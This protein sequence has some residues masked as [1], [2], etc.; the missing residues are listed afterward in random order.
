MTVTIKFHMDLVVKVRLVFDESWYDIATNPV[1]QAPDL[2]KL[3]PTAWSQVTDSENE[4]LNF[5]VNSSWG[6]TKDIQN[7][8]KP[9]NFFYLF[10]IFMEI[11]KRTKI[12]M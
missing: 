1:T 6:G 8:D 2:L 12:N 11:D 5:Q 9:I 3:T 7:C 10:T 4:H